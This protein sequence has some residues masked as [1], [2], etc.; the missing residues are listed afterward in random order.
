[1]RSRQLH[2]GGANNLGIHQPEA[3]SNWRQRCRLGRVRNHRAKRSIAGYLLGRSSSR[4]T[5][6]HFMRSAGVASI[7]RMI[8]MKAATVGT[9]LSSITVSGVSSF[10]N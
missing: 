6:T 3:A 1:M 5:R 9:S 8:S 4:G 2:A 7:F 10:V